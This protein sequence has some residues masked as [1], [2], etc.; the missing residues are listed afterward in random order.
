MRFQSVSRHR[1]QGRSRRLEDQIVTLLERNSSSKGAAFFESIDKLAG[2]LGDAVYSSLLHTL[3]HLDFPPDRARE[4]WQHIKTHSEELCRK[5]GRETDF[6][7]ALLDY[8]V[9][10]NRKIENPV[11]IE[12]RLFRRTQESALIDQLTDLPNYRA[13]KAHLSREIKRAKRY[14]SPLSLI[15]LD[16]DDFKV[17]NDQYGHTLGNEALRQVAVLLKQSLR[18]VDIACRYGGEEFTVLLPETDKKGVLTLAERIRASIEEHRFENGKGR[19]TQGLTISGGVAT[20]GVDALRDADLLPLADLALYRAKGSGKNRIE[21]ASGEQ[22][23][24]LRVEAEFTGDLWIMSLRESR[25]VARNVSEGGILFH[26]EQPVTIGELLKLRFQPPNQPE[27]INCCARVTRVQESP[28]G[29]GFEAA[30]KF[31]G[32]S[33][34][35]Q[36]QLNSLIAH[37]HAKSRFQKEPR[38]SAGRSE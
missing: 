23:A 17:Y 34:R 10:I 29:D 38:R 18:D 32:L 35:D 16:I 15:M 3:T 9:K 22:R 14:R 37:A 27:P 7:V 21:A 31:I 2:H 12:I 28:R 5:I 1:S 24:Y 8:F 36:H 19:T 11:V 20:Y 4:H 30:A 13:F 6:R 25:F 26:T 33:H